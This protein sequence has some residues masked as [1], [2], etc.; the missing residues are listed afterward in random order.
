MTW[1]ALWSYALLVT[2]SI[3]AESELPYTQWFIHLINIHGGLIMSKALCWDYE[4]GKDELD[5]IF[6]NNGAMTWI[7]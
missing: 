5:W 1:V 3:Q 7:E 2:E 6:L 4:G